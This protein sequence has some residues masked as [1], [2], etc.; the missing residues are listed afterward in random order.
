MSSTHPRCVFDL[1]EI[2]HAL[3]QATGIRSGFPTGND[4]ARFRHV[5]ELD[6]LG[7]EKLGDFR[8][9]AA[10]RAARREAVRV[11]PLVFLVEPIRD[12]RR[13]VIGY[14]FGF[15]DDATAVAFRDAAMAAMC[16]RDAA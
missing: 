8:F 5:V 14:E 3:E 6:G 10:H 2:V 12:A 13:I 7:R 16:A 4:Y 15:A 11:A 9:G 1:R